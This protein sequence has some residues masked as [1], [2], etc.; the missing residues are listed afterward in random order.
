MPSE[1]ALVIGA[2][3]GIGA[4]IADALETRGAEVVRLSRSADGLDVTDP[5]SVETILG[6]VEGDFDLVFVATGALTSTRD[7]PEKSLRDLGADEPVAQFRLNALG[8]ALVL[9]HWQHR[10]PRKGRSVFAVLSARVGSI[11]DNGLGGWYSYRTSKAALN[12]LIHGAAVEIGRSRREAILVCLHPG[13]VATEFT[14]DYPDH[15][16]VTPAEAASN[17]LDVIDGLTPAQSGGFYDY[18]GKEIPW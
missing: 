11:G 5:A 13:T 7:A 4:A 18:A 2:S 10:I 12:A 1:R 17:L 3:G 8:P 9:K 14:E 16:K 15:D 6:G